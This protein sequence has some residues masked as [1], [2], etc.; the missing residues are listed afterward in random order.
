MRIE[1]RT[2]DEHIS[3]LSGD[4]RLFTTHDAGERDRFFSVGDDEHVGSQSAFDA[5]ERGELLTWSCAT[6]HDTTSSE[7]VEVE[8]VQ[9]LAQLV[10][11]IVRD[12]GDVVDRPLANCFESFGEPV[13]GWT[14]LHAAHEARGVTR[15][16][17]RIVD[18]NRSQARG[19]SFGFDRSF[20][21]QAQL[22]AL[23][24]RELA[25][26]TDV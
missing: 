19:F 4:L 3:R 17:I 1:I 25:C 24:N 16:Q 20:F 14:N 6:D 12:I 21:R 13:R 11:Y 18:L 7:F 5:V 9:R 23:D 22:L 2:L 10:K 15:T 8:C 26:D